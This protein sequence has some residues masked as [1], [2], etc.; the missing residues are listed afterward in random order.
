MAYYRYFTGKLPFARIAD[1]IAGE[2]SVSRASALRRCRQVYLKC[3]D[4][5]AAIALV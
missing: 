3:E 1:R 2:L 5:L 4:K